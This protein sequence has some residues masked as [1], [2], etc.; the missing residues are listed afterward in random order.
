M[1]I[2][3]ISNV[4]SIQADVSKYDFSQLGEICFALIDVD[5]Y[6]PVKSALQQVYP[7]MSSGGIIAV[8]DCKDNQLY[9]GALQA[10]SEFVESFNLPFEILNNKIGVIRK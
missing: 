4:T 8:D 10:Y 5:L 6:Y 2:N 1:S 3:H 9:D 7:L